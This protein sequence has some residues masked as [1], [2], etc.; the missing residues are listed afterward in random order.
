MCIIHGHCY[1]SQYRG[2]DAHV[3][4]LGS[5]KRLEQSKT[6]VLSKIQR[7]SGRFSRV[8]I[9]RSSSCSTEFHPGQLVILKSP[10]DVRALEIGQF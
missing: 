9:V 10:A 7:R 1:P 3:E 2:H 6:L 8:S 4:K 5:S